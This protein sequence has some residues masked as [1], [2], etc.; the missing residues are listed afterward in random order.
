[1]PAF[2]APL[3]GAV[4]RAAGPAIARAVGP[5][6]LRG[7]S[8]V[9]GPAVSAGA[10]RALPMLGKAAKS[11]VVRGAMIGHAVT[12]VMGGGQGGGRKENFDNWFPGQG[13]NGAMY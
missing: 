9:V 4:A 6:A 12:S 7:A 3:I 11:P 1:M 2:I 10:K 5:A 8:R 13:N